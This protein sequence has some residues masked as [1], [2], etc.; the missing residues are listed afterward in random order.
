MASAQATGKA[1]KGGKPGVGTKSPDQFVDRKDFDK[2][3]ET[4]DT[5]SDGIAELLK[6]SSAPAVAPEVEAEQK[7]VSKASPNKYTSNPEWEDIAREI[8]GE[9]VDHTEIQY[10]KGGGLLFTIVIKDEFSNAPDDYLERYKS[11]RRSREVGAEGEAGVRIWCELVRNN[12]KRAK[13]IT[14][15]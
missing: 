7:E 4:V 6:R 1:G 13:P 8:I 5:L 14:A 12:L 9:A 3:S 2:L 11:D 10:V 15:D